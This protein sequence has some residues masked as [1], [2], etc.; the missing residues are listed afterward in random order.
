[1][2]YCRSRSQCCKLLRADDFL[3]Q[4]RCIL[5]A[6]CIKKNKQGY[7]FHTFYYQL[8]TEDTCI[9]ISSLIC[10]LLIQWFKTKIHSPKNL[11]EE[12]CCK[13]HC[14]VPVPAFQDRYWKAGKADTGKQDSLK[15]ENIISTDTILDHLVFTLW[16][17]MKATGDISNPERYIYLKYSS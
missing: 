5:M 4:A 15:N 6:L 11:N 8:L 7:R 2:A 10:I 1:M 14:L 17:L 12:M 3:S 16:Y 13:M 9:K